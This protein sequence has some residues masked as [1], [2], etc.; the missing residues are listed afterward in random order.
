MF[1]V[2]ENT[3]SAHI[4]QTNG[5]ES[6]FFD[7]TGVVMDS[8]RLNTSS[9]LGGIF[10]YYVSG[11]SPE[12]LYDPVQDTLGDTGANRTSAAHPQIGDSVSISSHARHLSA[13]SSSAPSPAVPLTGMPS[14]NLALYNQ[15]RRERENLEPGDP[16]IIE[17]SNKL[18]AILAA[19]DKAL[20]PEE[21]GFVKQQSAAPVNAT[22]EAA[23]APRPV[24]SGESAAADSRYRENRNSNAS[25]SKNQRVAA[26]DDSALFA[27]HLS[28]STPEATADAPP[29][30]MRSSAS[31]P[32]RLYG[33]VPTDSST[34]VFSG[35][36]RMHRVA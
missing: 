10:P 23:P 2:P 9:A 21:L 32:S 12:T 15:I 22:G 35:Q 6:R 14:E 26:S 11:T 8:A 17:L 7:T 25:L 1:Q 4:L 30:A 36:A 5:C 19:G 27:P 34:A 31:S 16:R 18:R 3:P 33:Y 29:R 20:S 24:E 13:S 28:Y